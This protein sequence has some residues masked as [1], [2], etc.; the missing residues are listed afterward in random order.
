MKLEI[1]SPEILQDYSQVSKLEWLETNGLGGY[2]SGTLSGANTRRYHG[3]FVP[4]V[5]PPVGRRVLL[6][7]LEETVTIAGEQYIIPCSEFANYVYDEGQP[8][9]AKFS[10]EIFPQFDYQVEGVHL[11]KTIGMLHEKDVV[12]VTYQ[13]INAEVPFEL[14]LKP[15][16]AFKDFHS[17]SHG[18]EDISKV[19]VFGNNTLQIAPYESNE[20]LYIYVEQSSFHFKCEWCYKFEYPIE[21]QRGQDC[22]EDLFSYGHFINSLKTGDKISIVISSRPIDNKEGFLLLE[23]EKRRRQTILESLPIKDDFTRNLALA[24]DQ[25][26]VQ[27]GD[28]KTIIAGYHWFSDWGRDTM[29][30]LPGLCLVTGRYEDAKKIIQAFAKTVD[31]G[32]IPNRFPD[33][34]ETPEYNTVDATLWYFVAIKKYHDYSGD[35]TFITEQMLPVLEEIVAW[36]IRGTRYNIHVEEDELVYAGQLGVQLTWMD[37]KVGD[38]VVTPRQGKAVEINA[39][40]YN[41]MLIMAEFYTLKNHQAQ[42]DIYTQRAEKI[43]KSF[44]ETFVNPERNSLYD[45]VDGHYK[46]EDIRPNQL[47]AISLPYQIVSNEVARKVLKDVEA[48]LLTPVGLRSLAPNNSQYIGIYEGGQLSRDGSYHQGTVWS[49][50]LGPYITAKVKVEGEQG[51]VASLNFMKQLEQNLLQ[52]G[53]GTISEIFDGDAPHLPNGCMAQ[54]WGVSELLRVYVEDIYPQKN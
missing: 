47:F 51:R 26:L 52:A 36:H 12:V 19:A 1:T 24:A 45:Y 8:Y 9:L 22:H 34:G 18:N 42:V 33:A 37:A 3:M 35:T 13:V 28:L 49:W 7:K 20:S 27:R 39:L 17:L 54:A 21:K 15:F 5:H 43:K 10:K 16:V 41:A 30:A 38:W 14:H 25:F 29:I 44:E 2:A 50:L 31:M 53:V 46:N 40:W 11:Q 4:A 32:M 48:L 6:S 23:T